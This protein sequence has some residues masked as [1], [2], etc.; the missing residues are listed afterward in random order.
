[1]G[2]VGIEVHPF[3]FLIVFEEL[4]GTQ[5][6]RTVGAVLGTVQFA[7]GSGEIG[8]AGNITH[9]L[10]LILQPVQRIR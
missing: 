1:M 7:D 9:Y 5:D 4:A 2:A 3:E 8:T 10:P 6:R